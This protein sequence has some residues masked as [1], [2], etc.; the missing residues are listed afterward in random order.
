[1][2]NKE[3]FIDSN[4]SKLR[5]YTYNN[6]DS[7]CNSNNVI[8]C[9][10]CNNCKYQYVGQTSRK[11]KY[12]IKEHLYHIHKQDIS[13]YLYEHFKSTCNNANI[14]VT[15]LDS[16][17]SNTEKRVLIDKE[18]F[19]IKLLNT[20]YPFGLNDNIKGY[21]NISDISNPLD[22]RNNHPYYN[23]RIIKQRIRNGTVRNR[24]KNRNKSKEFKI[25]EFV[26]NINS[27]DSVINIYRYIHSLRKHD[28]NTI[29]TLSYN[30]NN[31]LLL[32]LNDKTKCILLSILCKF[33][34]NKN[35]NKQNSRTK[36]NTYCN[37][38]VKYIHNILDEI[39]LNKIFNSNLITEI[40]T[41]NS[42]VPY[43]PFRSVYKY[44]PPFSKHVFNYNSTLRNVR[45]EDLV[46]LLNE[47]CICK[48][49]TYKKY[50]NIH[51]K[52]V[53]TGDLTIVNDKG[54]FDIMSKGIKYKVNKNVSKQNMYQWVNDVSTDF[55]NKIKTKYRIRSNYILED[56]KSIFRNKL[57]KRLKPLLYYRR[58][59]NNQVHKYN[60]E[61]LNNL[62]EKFVIC[63][64]DKASN[65][66]S[67]ICKKL[68]L[69]TVMKE[70]GIQYNNDILQYCN[71][72][73]TYQK[74]EGL[75]AENIKHK[76]SK[77]CEN[78]R[79]KNLFNPNIPLIYCL[80]K[81]HKTPVK[82]RFITGASNSTIKPLSIELKNI[83]TFI[84]THFQRYVKSVKARNKNFIEYWSIDDINISTK[85]TNI[86]MNNLKLFS[87]DF[88][89]MFTNLPHKIIIKNINK[90]L[91]ICFKNADKKYIA[92]S[93]HKNI[94]YTNDTKYPKHRYYTVTDLL[95]YIDYL[96]N[97]SFCS[98]SQTV[99]KQINGVPQGGNFSPLLADLTLSIFEYQYSLNNIN[100][101]R[102]F[103]PYRYM[104]DILI[105]HNTNEDKVN[106]ILQEVY[107]NTLVLEKTHF[108]Q[109]HCNYLDLEIK[110]LN[111]K[112]ITRLFN[113]TDNFDFKV[114]RFPHYQSNISL[115]VKSSVIYTEV[116]R[117]A[118]TTSLLED[119]IIQIK[120]LRKQFQSNGYSNDLIVK[121]IYKCIITNYFIVLKYNLNTQF[122]KLHKFICEVVS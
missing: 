56:I 96:L 47:D 94:Y 69:M 73:G 114:I 8:Y 85:L 76:H 24:N 33:H 100:K 39:N 41:L 112:I 18:L 14:T 67:I 99:Y 72:T 84:K 4:A 51:H 93:G 10:T 58:L 86:K 74:L 27:L 111:D 102:T 121:S 83:F 49:D 118:R 36:I 110:I 44:H 77:L 68:Y 28:I 7:N 11:L 101:T 113:K 54:L 42:N 62:Q 60:N 15:I 64:L 87:A 65:N 9:I 57:I 48:E 97:N 32:N 31:N 26:N 1:M 120:H 81:L 107:N 17:T 70:M 92:C 13:N 104:D 25:D 79:I 43:T 105:I 52:H 122:K 35:N 20:A 6:H 66:Y 119:F 91:N 80:P 63:P 37:I 109:L 12:R 98:F 61:Y 82:F 108:S 46:R 38:E 59:N 117:L 78:L 88:T 45:P 90:L 103:Y 115:N 29:T 34:F 40:I 75:N 116:L 22:Y 2:I 89:N 21:G 3:A 106:S 16:L 30:N 95:Y 53:I 71:N 19:W 50:I 5:I 55:Q 23:L